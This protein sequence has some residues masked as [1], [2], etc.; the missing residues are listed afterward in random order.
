MKKLSECG[1]EPE[2]LELIRECI[3]IFNASEVTI[4]DRK[5]SSEGHKETPDQS[6]K[7][8]PSD[9]AMVGTVTDIQ[10]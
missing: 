2:E 8:L 1:F 9:G 6:G 3:R 5:R 7:L 10:R 4:Y